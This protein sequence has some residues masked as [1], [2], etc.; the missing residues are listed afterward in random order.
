M[1]SICARPP[2]L[3]S[4]FSFLVFLP[5]P[6]PPQRR[7]FAVY[8]HCH[9]FPEL[10]AAT[11]RRRLVLFPLRF[12]NDSGCKRRVD[13][14]VGLRS[15]LDIKKESPAGARL[16]HNGFS[17]ECLVVVSVVVPMV[18]DHLS[19]NFSAGEVHRVQIH[20]AGTLTDGTQSA[21]Q[22]PGCNALGRRTG[23]VGRSDTACESS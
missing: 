17:M 12:G 10:V 21:S 7:R 2:F 4:N 6:T 9:S 8:I 22:V 14:R 11:L 23:N 1:R 20:V 15:I 3:P 16:P 19:A 5:S 18:D 13:C